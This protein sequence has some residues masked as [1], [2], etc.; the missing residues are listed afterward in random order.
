MYRPQVGDAVVT[1][2]HQWD[3]YCISRKRGE[4][5]KEHKGRGGTPEPW[6]HHA[7]TALVEMPSL[8]PWNSPLVIEWRPDVN[9]ALSQCAKAS[10]IISTQPQCHWSEQ[11][12]HVEP[13]WGGGDVGADP[14]TGHHWDDA[15]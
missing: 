3:Y 13:N 10:G 8:K 11:H 6:Q 15:P 14:M 1:V 12:C 2:Q 5:H 7:G 4:E 9:T